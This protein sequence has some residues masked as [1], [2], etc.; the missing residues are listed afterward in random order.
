M[1]KK[2]NK[3]VITCN[4]PSIKGEKFVQ[5]ALNKEQRACLLETILYSK[6]KNECLIHVI[7]ELGR[8]VRADD[9]ERY[10]KICLK[11]L[12]ATKCS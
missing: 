3:D 12:V 9:P 6:K 8:H 7:D 10:E 11:F 1:P 4:D 5:I 2:M